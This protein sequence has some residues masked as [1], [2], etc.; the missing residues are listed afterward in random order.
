VRKASR[1][2]RLRAEPS[3]DIEPLDAGEHPHSSSGAMW[4]FFRR[5]VV[6]PYR[7]LTPRP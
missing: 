6:V 5:H 2:A 4:W 3:D 7:Q 1:R